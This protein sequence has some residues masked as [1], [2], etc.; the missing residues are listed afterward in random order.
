MGIKALRNKLAT[1][2]T[3]ERTLRTEAANLIEAA[4]K[5]DGGKPTAEQDTR[6][7]AIRGRLEAM[8][9]DRDAVNF[10]IANAERMADLERL[11][12]G[13]P[14][15]VTSGVREAWLDDPKRGYRTA[16]SLIV[17]IHNATLTGRVSPR[18][19]SLDDSRPMA[20]A[21]S[22]E[23]STQSDPYGGFFIPTGLLGGVK[24]VSPDADP[25]NGLTTQVDMTGVR[26]LKVNARVD[27]DHSTSVSGGL[28]VYR[29]V[30]TQTVTP[31]RMQFEQVEFQKNEQMGVTYA[32]EEGSSR[33]RPWRS[34][35]SSARASATSSRQ[36]PSRSA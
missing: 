30:E 22:D 31:K 21:G 10:A 32:T 20:T 14:S 17:D 25:L 33:S 18:T 27:K 29:R 19:A 3:E 34:R 6:L 2:D 15:A 36:R 7:D 24:T 23:Q 5:N 26:T 1:L 16:A 35:P 28:V 13:A 9:N 11:Q 12:S 4:E 8:K